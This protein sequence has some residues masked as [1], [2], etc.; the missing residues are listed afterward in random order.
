MLYTTSLHLICL[1]ILIA[2]SQARWDILQVMSDDLTPTAVGYNNDLVPSPNVVSLSKESVI[3]DNAYSQFPHCLPSRRSMFAGRY[4]H[5]ADKNLHLPQVLKEAGYH[6][7]RLGKIYHMGIPRTVIKGQDGAYYNRDPKLW[8]ESH[9]FKAKENQSPGKKKGIVGT[10]DQSVVVS[11]TYTQELHDYKVA[12]KSIQ[13]L[14]EFKKK[15]K[16]DDN[17]NFYMACG[18]IRPHP[19]YVV[20]QSFYDKIDVSKLELRD[21]WD[22]TDWED[23]YDKNMITNQ[24]TR[25]KLKGSDPIDEMRLYYAAVAFMDTQLGRVLEE[26]KNLNMY[27]STIII[28]QS[29]HGYLL[30]EHSLWH[31][32]STSSR[33]EV[34]IT[35]LT[36]RVPP[37]DQRIFCMGRRTSALVELID[38]YPT[39]LDLV[40]LPPC[41]KCSGNSFASLL[42]CPQT[43]MSTS[44]FRSMAASCAFFPYIRSDRFAITLFKGKNRVEL[45][46]MHSDPEQYHNLAYEI[47][48]GIPNSFSQE[49]ATE[50]QNMLDEIPRKCDQCNYALMDFEGG[51]QKKRNFERDCKKVNKPDW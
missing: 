46:D 13:L 39:I 48:G 4:L 1:L 27:N 24:N 31:K 49:E 9:S 26:L 40:G 30:G 15:K 41:N 7:V 47:P 2:T 6:T 20:P 50:V 28:F 43:N 10:K 21:P 16:R 19:P 29:D 8:T 37:G 45:Y 38:L 32:A 22:P 23:M 42:R 18:F 51:R 3:F 44:V 36:V 25:T 33:E 5:L 11:N 35:P 14:Q 34:S 12:S 17:F